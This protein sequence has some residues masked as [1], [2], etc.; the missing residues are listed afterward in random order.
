MKKIFNQN[1]SVENYV[2]KIIFS[3]NESGKNEE[4]YNDFDSF[5][6]NTFNLTKENKK[7]CPSSWM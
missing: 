6:E 1:K 5:K 2:K 3:D 7:S 4:R